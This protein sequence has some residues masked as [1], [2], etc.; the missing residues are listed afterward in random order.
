[1]QECEHPSCSNPRLKTYTGTDGNTLKLCDV[2]YYNLV[3][4]KNLSAAN[5]NTPVSIIGNTGHLDV[6]SSGDS[7]SLFIDNNKVGEVTEFSITGEYNE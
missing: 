2:H 1:M 6:S 7:T 5:F 4:G 3:S